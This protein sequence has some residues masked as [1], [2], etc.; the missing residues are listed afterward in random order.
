MQVVC[1]QDESVVISG[2]V[3][4]TIR[5]WN[6]NSKAVNVI[7]CHEGAVTGLSLHATG[8]YILSSSLDHHWAFSDIRTGT[9]LAKVIGDEDAALTSAKFHPDGLIFATGTLNSEIKIW[10]LKEQNNVA[11]FAGHTGPVTAI[12]FSENGYYLATASEDSSVKI[13][14][15]RKLKNIKTI[16]MNEG[17]SISDLS[18][19]QSGSYLG[20]IGKDVRIYGCK[21]WNELIVFDNHTDVGTGIRFG[22]NMDFIASTSMDRSLKIYGAGA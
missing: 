10:D 9:V 3:D 7:R 12:S 6:V 18:F 13:W 5:I 11:N 16:E 21:T 19:D 22:G 15:L 14:D 17:F 2:S 1:H 4:S 20:F 8:D